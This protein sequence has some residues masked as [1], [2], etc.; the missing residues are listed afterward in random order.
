MNR[1]SRTYMPAVEANMFL[2]ADEPNAAASPAKPAGLGAE[3]RKH[4][5]RGQAEPPPAQRVLPRK[6]KR[7][8]CQTTLQY[9][10]RFLRHGRRL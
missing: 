7:S 9:P 3:L 6:L 10:D 1:L 5:P 4:T 8:L 2:Q